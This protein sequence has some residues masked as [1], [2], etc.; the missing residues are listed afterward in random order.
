MDQIK[1]ATI[2]PRE[3][4][5]IE[6]DFIKTKLLVFDSDC[7]NATK[8][9]NHKKTQPYN[10]RKELKDVNTSTEECKKQLSIYLVFKAFE[11]RLCFSK[12]L[13]QLLFQ[14]KPKVRISE[15]HIYCYLGFP[16]TV[17][18]VLAVNDLSNSFPSPFPQE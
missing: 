7:W 3:A 11:F 13:Q 6:G 14:M 18:I 4:T 5:M 8:K 9:K 16:R 10:V 17:Y 15:F 1:E 2:I 12:T